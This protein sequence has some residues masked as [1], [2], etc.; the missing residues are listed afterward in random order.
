MVSYNFPLHR[1]DVV[2]YILKKFESVN[3]KINIDKNNFKMFK[4]SNYI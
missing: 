3:L 1:I 4:L 2:G